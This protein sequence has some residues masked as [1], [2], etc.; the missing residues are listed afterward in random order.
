MFL[1]LKLA[2]GENKLLIFNVW[3]L[4]ILRVEMKNQGNR[5]NVGQE[6]ATAS[7]GVICT[8]SADCVVGWTTLSASRPG[9]LGRR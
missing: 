7:T 6:D 3:Q 4:Q 9:P 2:S 8:P 5:T 1:Y